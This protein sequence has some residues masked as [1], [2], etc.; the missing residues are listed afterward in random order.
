MSSRRPRSQ[1]RQA[2]GDYARAAYREAI[3]DA[4]ARLFSR[5]GY[6][7]TKMSDLAGEAGVAVGTLYKHFAS[8]EVVL[9]SLAE[10]TESD[11]LE[12]MKGAAA[13]P[14]PLAR[15]AGT[16]ARVIEYVEARGT[17]F[18]LFE[19]RGGALEAPGSPLSEPARRASRARFFATLESIIGDAVSTGYLRDDVAVSTMAVMLFG[20]MHAAVEAWV[21]AEP[22]YS[23]T[24]QSQ[25]LM[26]LFL[27]GATR[28]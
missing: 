4:A 26:N 13:A 19:E 18:A 14:D 25:V 22:R 7:D 6:H 2:V 16:V 23:L 1:P 11:L 28:Q 20:A 24:E 15:L 17:V 27:E 10:R 3:L 21:R 8:K 5:A 12:L 9:A